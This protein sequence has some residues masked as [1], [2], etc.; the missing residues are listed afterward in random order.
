[1]MGYMNWP[2]DRLG[3]LYHDLTEYHHY[4][5]GPQSRP[6]VLFVYLVRAWMV[7]RAV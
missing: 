4:W 3:Q 7:V 2:G 1:M 5:S 6:K